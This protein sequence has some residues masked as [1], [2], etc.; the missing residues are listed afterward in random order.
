[1]A[2]T[3]QTIKPLAT[4]VAIGL[5]IFQIYFTAGFDVMDAPMLRAIHLGAVMTLIFMWFPP[6][7]VE[8]GKE[9]H[10]LWLVLDAVLICLS[11]AVA[12]YLVS[13]IEYILTRIRYVDP[14]TTEDMVYG[15][16]CILLVLEVTRRTSG[17][18]L[19]V[20]SGCFLLYALVGEHLPSAISHGGISYEMLMEQLYLL[21]DGVYG[22]PLA[23]ASTMIFAFVM[24]GAFLECSGLSRVF[25]EISCVA[26]RKSAGGPAKVAIFASALFGTISGSAAANVYGTGTFTI[27]LMKRV[28]YSG[29]F[30]GAVEA[31]AST[32]GQLMPPIMGAA[33]FVM[34]DLTGAGYL[35][36]AKAALLPS[37]LYYAAL[38]F[39]IHF[40]AV[41]KGIGRMPEELIPPT[42]DVMK[43][44]YYI[45][46]I[47]ILIIFL[48]VGW[49]VIFSAFIGTLSVV[50]VAAFHKDTRFT[51]SKFL[52]A[53]EHSA[54]NALMIS[55]CCACAGI[56]V[57]IM[58]L[59]GVGYKF[60]NLI[61]TIGGDHLLLLMVLL[62]L[63]CIILGMGV[64]TTPA[65]V[66]VATL[67][68][69]ALMKMGVDP[70]PAHLFVLYFAI[71]SVITPPVCLASYAG[72][73]I[74]EAPAMK[75]GFV[76]A[77]L[78]I[79][80]FIIP[81][82]FVFQPALLLEGELTT[83][84]GAVVTSLVGVI[85][86]SAGMQGW[87]I[88]ACRA[89]ERV[90]LVAGGLMLIYPGLVTDLIGCGLIGATVMLQ[91]PR[92]Q[93]RR[94]LAAEGIQQ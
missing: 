5:S 92:R 12:Y 83:V 50:I 43:R 81:F 79:V 70:L 60:I 90:F 11:I 56:I 8:Q 27:P 53:L 37:I 47:V 31:V 17:W 15:T 2:I 72:A 3:R 29:P 6:V 42:R 19:V 24:F 13:Q 22:I 35:A 66:I 65:Y 75:T 59:T 88:A 1:M 85:G 68:A 26:T 78:G 63:T 82:M 74:A 23:V 54:R 67:G 57:G 94:E 80:A 55:A 62:M 89:Y 84:A 16:I 52:K 36:V 44:L 76:A 49:S 7:K 73:A 18:A 86:L 10:P 14:V 9:E 30:A 25:M 77:K 46:P 34:A 20:V 39:M 32:G 33:A 51:L 71:L 45:L 48:V 58:A 91:L 40:E 61:T 4:A 87:F 38:F 64:P 69:P 28:G 93:S 21:T 41:G